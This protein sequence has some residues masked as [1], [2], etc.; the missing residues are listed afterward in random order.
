M[1]RQLDAPPIDAPP[2]D[3]LFSELEMSGLKPKYDIPSEPWASPTALSDQVGRPE[4]AMEQV[5]LGRPRPE[6]EYFGRK[7]LDIMSD[8]FIGGDTTGQAGIYGQSL[9]PEGRTPEWRTQAL[10]E[11]N[12]PPMPSEET[13][14]TANQ[15]MQNLGLFGGPMPTPEQ[16]DPSIAQG[17]GVHPI[18][19]IMA[20][21]AQD[22]KSIG[23]GKLMDTLGKSQMKRAEG[24]SDARTAQMWKQ[25]LNP[26]LGNQPRSL[27]TKTGTGFLPN[28]GGN[29]RGY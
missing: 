26:N 2:T 17:V 1:Y 13:F 21:G 23:Y 25:F 27:Y 6:G 28:L 9:F 11:L 8:Q 5:G 10:E 16:L 24:L 14:A 4:L 22:E 7:P 3:A 18:F 19:D 29:W 20:G 12:I 15:S